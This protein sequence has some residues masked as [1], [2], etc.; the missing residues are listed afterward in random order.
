MEGEE[1]GWIARRSRGLERHTLD[2]TSDPLF[3]LDRRTAIGL[4]V[5]IDGIERK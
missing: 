3:I 4:A 2:L 1:V 5:L